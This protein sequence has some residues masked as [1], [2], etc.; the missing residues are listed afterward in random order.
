M[1][2]R[3]EPA[4]EL[5][6]DLPTEIHAKFQVHEE[7]AESSEPPLAQP[8]PEPVKKAVAQTK[9]SQKKLKPT[10]SVKPVA[11]KGPKKAAQAVAR[12][13]AL[14]PESNGEE[15]APAQP[16]TYPLRRP[17]KDP[18]WVGEKHVF[19][20]TYF[21]MPA[22]EVSLEVMPHKVIN[23]R[24]VYHV[25][26]HAVSSK[27]FGLFYKLDDTIQTFF[28]YDSLFSHRFQM[29]LNESKQ[30]KNSIELNDTEKS[31]SYFWNR[32]NHHKKG[33]IEVKKFF[34]MAPFSQ[35]TLSALYYLRTLPLQNGKVYTFPVISEGKSWEAVV[36]VLGREKI[37]TPNGEK[38]TIK[39]KPE[40]K[41]QGILKKRGDSFLWL[42]DDARRTVVKLEAKVKLG[43]V[44]TELKSFKPGQ[45]PVE[46]SDQR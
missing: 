27:A 22:G 42:T 46:G 37:T 8:T 21:G 20:I 38:M 14:S 26:G 45:R 43:T 18:I 1:F 23:E 7:E 4:E 28:D 44:V 39:L 12:N 15:A 25:V 40:T 19:E 36:T 11:A 32:W 17:V 31:R 6:Q 41:F 13:T 33:Y 35:D 34:P 29:E 24:K 9:P 3:I 30:T 16:I 10:S 2:S 5:P